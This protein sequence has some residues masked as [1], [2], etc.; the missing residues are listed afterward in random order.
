M[1]SIKDKSE[2][3]KL[4]VLAIAEPQSGYFYI[5]INKLTTDPSRIV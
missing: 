2:K 1:L 4:I 5:I 3:N